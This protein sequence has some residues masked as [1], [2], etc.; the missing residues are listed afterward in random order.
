MYFIVFFLLIDKTDEYQLCSFIMAFKGIQFLTGGMFPAFIGAMKYY[1]CVAKPSLDKTL[2][3]RNCERDGPGE[4]LWVTIFFLIQ[5]LVVWCAF[6]M[7]PCSK[8][9]GGRKFRARG[10][11][12][13]DWDLD[14]D[15]LLDASELQIMRR[16]VRN[17]DVP[18]KEHPISCGCCA[19]KRGRGGKLRYLFVWDILT[20]ALT[21]ALMI[22]AAVQGPTETAAN[23]QL[24]ERNWRLTQTLW[25]CK[26]LYGVLAIPFVIFKIPVLFTL[27]THAKPTGYAFNGV[28]API[29][30]PTEA[31]G[32]VIVG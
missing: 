19:I 27:L 14:D 22:W 13:Q 32:D 6:C 8:K 20:F 1:F 30:I 18:K 28:T 17:G 11:E 16:G 4:E 31:D 25:W 29:M 15:G 10:K 7:L 5:V 21:L 23:S 9:K 2:N 26:V 12:E 24:H 3:N